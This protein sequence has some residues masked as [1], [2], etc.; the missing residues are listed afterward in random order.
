MHVAFEVADDE[1]VR[2]ARRRRDVAQSQRFLAPNLRA[3]LAVERDDGI[4]IVRDVDVVEVRTQAR[5]RRQVLLPEH[6]A[7]LEI[8]ADGAAVIA[9]DVDVVAD[10]LQTRADVDQALELAAARGIRDRRPPKR[11]R[12]SRARKRRR[13]RC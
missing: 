11:D 6:D 8:D 9:D 4:E 5:V 7:G 13:G 2:V 3:G 10:D 12:R 1:R